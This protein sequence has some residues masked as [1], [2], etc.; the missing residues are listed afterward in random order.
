MPTTTAAVLRAPDGPFTIETLDLEEPGP[1]EAL[2]KL[3]ASGMCHTDLSMRDAFRPTPYPVVL[4][5]EG[6]GQIEAVGPGVTD[7][8]IGQPVVL[9]HASCGRCRFCVRGEPTYCESMM[10][11]NFPCCRLDGSTSLSDETGSVGS[12]FFGQSSFSTHAVVPRSSI[13][14]VSEDA[15][16]ELLGPLGCGVQTGAGAVFNV[17]E[18]APG[19]A[20]VVFGCGAVGLSAVLAAVVSGCNPIIGV[21]VHDGRLE[22]A[23]R[24]GATHTINSSR[25]DVVAALLDV[26]GGGV[27]YAFDAVGAPGTFEAA[28]ESL[29]QRGTCGFVAAG[30]PDQTATV[31]L[32]PLL[33]GK[34]IT[35]ILEG[36]AVSS[37]FIPQLIELQRQG[38]FPFD[39]LITTFSLAEINEAEAASKSGEAIK[40]VLLMP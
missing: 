4:G 8:T 37:L 33:M 18:P 5:H 24:L 35:G 22:A 27:D 13:V 28:V 40:P 32:R 6:S 9:S 19:D 11:L 10:A 39:E 38:R 20:L 29:A 26:T 3:V 25:D 7:L 16:L 34:T 14:P 12:H 21:D 17:F 23:T 36:S 30:G 15:P 2:V 1:G 31:S